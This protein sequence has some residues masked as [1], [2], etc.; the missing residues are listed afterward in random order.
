M[1][2]NQFFLITICGFLA[3]NLFV[4]TSA[5]L[6]DA[7]ERIG[8]QEV[9][10]HKGSIDYEVV[11]TFGHCKRNDYLFHMEKVFKESYSSWAETNR[12][13]YGGGPIITCIKARNAK[14][15]SRSAEV[16]LISGG[17]GFDNVTLGFI[18]K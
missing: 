14:N 18:G 5:S 3:G 6:D 1:R 9:M 8:G 16:F 13:I 12:I 11:A 2:S 4:N 10:I 17:E 15:S 7:T